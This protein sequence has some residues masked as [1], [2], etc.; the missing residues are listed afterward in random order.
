MGRSGHPGVFSRLCF[1]LRGWARIGFFNGGRSSALT[2]RGG[3][4][5]PQ[6]LW[7]GGDVIALARVIV[8]GLQ[9]EQG[10]RGFFWTVWSGRLA[11][12]DGH[13]RGVCYVAVCPYFGR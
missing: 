11:W 2:V 8:H 10:P 6:S 9:L 4:C 7:Q 3:P 1:M 13:A 12:V 5:D